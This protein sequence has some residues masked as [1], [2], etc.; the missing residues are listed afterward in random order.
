VKTMVDYNHNGKFDKEDLLLMEEDDRDV[1][2]I[3]NADTTLP[4]IV[5][6]LIVIGIIVAI[7]YF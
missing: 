5:V 6:V 7:K 2:K 4:T 3:K 1:D